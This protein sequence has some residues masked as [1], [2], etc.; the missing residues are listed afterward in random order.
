MSCFSSDRGQA[1]EEEQEDPH[2]LG[3]AIPIERAVHLTIQTECQSMKGLEQGAVLF[4]KCLNPTLIY[5]EAIDLIEYE[6]ISPSREQS[7]HFAML[8]LGTPTRTA[9]HILTCKWME[10]SN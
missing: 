1:G 8:C 6:A 4:K 9:Q 7:G 3:R 2:T 10:F 5:S